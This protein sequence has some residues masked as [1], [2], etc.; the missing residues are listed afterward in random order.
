V[1]AH[2]DVGRLIWGQWSVRK[3][4]SLSRTCKALHA[5]RRA[6]LAEWRTQLRAARGSRRAKSAEVKLAYNG[7]LPLLKWMHRP[8]PARPWHL[9]V[10]EAAVAGGHLDVLRWLHGKTDK[11]DGKVSWHAIREGNLEVL[12][13]LLKR[14]VPCG[15]WCIG[16]AAMQGRAEVMK[17][18]RDVGYPFGD[19]HRALSLQQTE[20]F[21]AKTVGAERERFGQVIALIRAW[22]AEC[23]EAV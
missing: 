17:L 13:W 22:N 2:P 23:G 11:W 19:E 18:L 4:R 16:Y 10:A 15:R 14:R 5:L 7:N 3:T 20:T 12:Q 1:L 8:V 21:Y 9:Y 6:Q